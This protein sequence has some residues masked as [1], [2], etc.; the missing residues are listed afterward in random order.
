[1]PQW[2]YRVIH[3]NVDSGPAPQP[4]DPKTAS[5]HLQGVLSPNFLAREFPEHYGKESE[6]ARR[7]LHPAEQLQS[8]LNLLGREGWELTETSQVGPLLMFFFKRPLRPAPKLIAA[9]G[10]GAADGSGHGDSTT[11]SEDESDSC[12]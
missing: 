12:P 1:M 11:G 7:Q 5:D 3:I 2:E 9:A 10:R 8:F 6:A 4:P